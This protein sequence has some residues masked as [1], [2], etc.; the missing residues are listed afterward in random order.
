MTGEVT[1][2]TWQIILSAVSATMD[3]SE[4]RQEILLG[5]KYNK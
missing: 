1:V 5:I 3:S 4:D 2:V